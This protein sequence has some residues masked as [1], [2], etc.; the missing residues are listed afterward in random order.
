MNV[1]QTAFLPAQTPVNTTLILLA[2][3]SNKEKVNT[4]TETLNFMDYFEGL[5]EKQH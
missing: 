1:K 4:H 5:R 2:N 3:S